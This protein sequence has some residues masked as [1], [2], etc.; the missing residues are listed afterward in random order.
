LFISAQRGDLEPCPFAPW[1]DTNVLEVPQREA[2]GSHFPKSIRENHALFA[3]TSGGCALY[4]NK[5]AVEALFNL[6][7]GPV[8]PASR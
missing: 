6:P 2:L 5:H 1:S 3:E 4:E 8:K 7:T